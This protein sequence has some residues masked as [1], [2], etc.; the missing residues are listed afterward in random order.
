MKLTA[1]VTG[2]S[3]GIGKA[4]VREFSKTDMNVVINYNQSK[5]S[6]LELLEEI[7]SKGT[8]AIAIK[9]DVSDPLQA[10][11]LINSA[12]QQFGKV[13]IL[14]NNAG[15]SEQKLFTDIT[16]QDW[17]KMFAINV[18]GMFNCSKVAVKDMLKRHEGKI[19]N[20]SSVW[21]ITG[22]S[23]EVHYS[24]SK[25]AIIGFTK[26]LAKELGPS[27]INVNCVAPGVIK[28]KMNEFL[29]ASETADLIDDIPL[30][31]IG[32]AEEVAKTV[33]F[34][35][36]DDANYLTGQIISPNGGFLI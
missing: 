24:S 28:T 6:A 2:S 4:I 10:S 19:I 13:D 22:A 17:R 8:S 15:I 20:I 9:A 18:D 11:D 31:R 21:G 36:S 26:S 35:A 25:A 7:K 34:L 23:C 14:V 3:S 1:V 32:S 30:G 16:F 27:N 12:V 5:E 33:G 29:N